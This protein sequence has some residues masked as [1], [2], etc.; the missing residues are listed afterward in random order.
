MKKRFKTGDLIAAAAVLVLA[1]ICWLAVR[2]SAGGAGDTVVVTVEEQEY[3][4]YPINEDREILITNSKG[5]ENLLTI[6]GGEVSM[7]YSDCK[8]Q[9]CVNT[10]KISEEGELIV[11]LPHKVVVSIESR[12]NG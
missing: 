6:E 10:G 2:P 12:E 8:N 5:E 1:L 4:S 3:G 9:V 11:C 7:S